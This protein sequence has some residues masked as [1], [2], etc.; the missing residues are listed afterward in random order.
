MRMKKAM[1]R[2]HRCTVRPVSEAAMR[3][4]QERGEGR[5]DWTQHKSDKD[6][7]ETRT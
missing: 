7:F 4:S 6:P 2:E 1:L 3:A 5:V